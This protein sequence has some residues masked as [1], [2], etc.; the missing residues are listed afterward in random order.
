MT[1]EGKTQVQLAAP[2]LTMDART[3]SSIT[4]KWNKVENASGYA[5]YLDGDAVNAAIDANTTS[6]KFE[7]LEGEA[8]TSYAFQIV[9]LGV[10][11]RDY[12]DS[13]LSEKFNF[14]TQAILATPELIATANSDTEIALSWK[15]VA[16]ATGYTLTYGENTQ[17]LEASDTSFVAK[18]LRAGTEYAFAITATSE[19]DDYVNSTTANASATTL[20]KLATPE[21]TVTEQTENSIKLNWTGIEGANGYTLVYSKSEDVAATSVPLVKGS[22]SYVATGLESGAKYVFQLVAN[23]EAGKSVD[24]EPGATNEVATLVKINPPVNVTVVEQTQHSIKITWEGDP[25]ATSYTVTYGLTGQTKTQTENVNAAEFELK[26]LGEVES[27]TFQIVANPSGEEFVSSDPATIKVSTLGQLA[28]PEVYNIQRSETTISFEWSAVGQATGYTLTYGEQ[29]GAEKTFTL[30]ATTKKYSFSKL[31]EG[32]TYTFKLSAESDGFVGSEQNVFDV[33]THEQLAAPTITSTRTTTSIRLSWEPITNA[34]S[35]E[36]YRNG[37]LMNTY[38]G[39]DLTFDSTGLEQGTEYTFKL[40]AI[41]DKPEDVAQS[42]YLDSSS[43]IKVTTQKQLNAPTLEYVT[44]SLDNKGTLDD[45]SDDKASIT[46]RWNAVDDATSYTLR[47]R[48]DEGTW[49]SVDASQYVLQ[50]NAYTCEVKNLAT[51]TTYEFEVIARGD[52]PN[53][54]NSEAAT[55]TQVTQKQLDAPKLEFDARDLNSITVKWNAVDDETENGYTLGYRAGTTGEFTQVD[56]ANFTK[57]GDAYTCVVSGL[58]EATNYQFQLVAKGTEN[59]DY[60]DSE[61]ATLKDVTKGTLA[62]PRNLAATHDMSSIALT[63]DAVEHATKYQVVF[64]V[65]DSVTPNSIEVTEPRFSMESLGPGVAYT[66]T[67]TA[68]G[69]ENY[70]LASEAAETTAQTQ[71]KLVASAPELQARATDSLTVTWEAVEN[72]TRY[73]LYRDGVKVYEGSNTSYTDRG[74][75]NTVLTPGASYVY[76]VVALGDAAAVGDAGNYLASEKSTQATFVT[77][78]RLD[79]PTLE[80]GSRTE[81]SI[82][83][84]WS[85]V[86]N[87]SGYKLEYRV[88]GATE[89]TTENVDGTSY[90]A[91]GLTPAAT[92]EFKLTAIGDGDPTA[93]AT[94]YLDSETS[95]ILEKNTQATLDAPTLTLKEQSIDSIT[96]SW[97]LIENATGYDLYKN[98]AKITTINSGET[99]SYVVTDLEAGGSY[100]Y[101]IKAKG[102]S[103][104][105]PSDP[106]FMDSGKSVALTIN[107]L[108]EPTITVGET[109]NESIPLSWNTPTDATGTTLE[110]R[111]KGA[112]EWTAVELAEGA[113][114]YTLTGQLGD[115][116]TYEFRVVALGDLEQKF[117]STA[118]IEEATT[119][120]KLA[121]PTLTYVTREFDDNETAGNTSDDTA[122]ISFTWTT[123]EGADNYTLYYKANV[124]GATE[125]VV[126]GLTATDATG[127]T[128]SNLATGT[129]YSIQ[130][131]ANGSG[132]YVSSDRSA[133]ITATTQ[134][135]LAQPTLKLKERTTG[136]ITV[137]W[138]GNDNATGYALKIRQGD[139]QVFSMTLGAGQTEF[140]Y[141]LSSGVAYTYELVA[142]GT[143]NGDYIDSEKATLTVATKSQLAA[144]TLTSA[145]VEGDLTKVTISWDAIDNATGY[146]LYLGGEKVYDGENTSYI[147]S[148]LEAGA[149]Y[150]FTIKAKGNDNENVAVTEVPYVDSNVSSALVVTK[151]AKPTIAVGERTANSIAITWDEVANAT[152][153]EIYLGDTM[154]DSKGANATRSYTFTGLEGAT[155]YN[156]LKVVAVG[157]GTT[158]VSTAA[159]ETATTK[160]QLTASK[161]SLTSRTLNSAGTV[162]TMT[163]SWVTSANATGYELYLDGVAVNAALDEDAT[164][165]TFENLA[166]GK[167]YSIQLVAKGSGEYVDSAKS[168]ALTQK[169]QAKLA[170][171][172]INVGGRTHDSIAL[173]WDS[174]ANATSYKL[175]G[176]NNSNGS[177]VVDETLTALEYTISGLAPGT[178]Y[179]FTIEAVASSD[180]YVSNSREVEATTKTQL[181][182][183][184]V[185][186]S[187]SVDDNNAIL[188]GK[189]TATWESVANATGYK[190]VCTDIKTQEKKEQDVDGTTASFEELENGREYKIEV[191]AKGAGEFV[192]SEAGVGSCTTAVQLDSPTIASVTRT[193]ASITVNWTLPLPDGATA[194]QLYLYDEDGVEVGNGLANEEENSHSFGNLIPGKKY[195]IKLYAVADGFVTSEAATQE[196]KTQKQLDQVTNPDI[197]FEEGNAILTWSP[198]ANAEGY[199]LKY[200][201]KGTVDD[202]TSADS[203]E[204]VGEVVHATIYGVDDDTPYGYTLITKAASGDDPDYIDSE[205][206]EGGFEHGLGEE[207]Y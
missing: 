50:N 12:A 65:K 70:Y 171:P 92:Y 39:T 187:Q 20:A 190:V 178:G 118:K 36:L 76:E 60:L 89:W 164:S 74:F 166:A 120:T 196:V 188:L 27:Y 185:T 146:E 123:S 177:K 35:Y 168:E 116:T 110:Y 88:K 97:N 131:V 193:T 95:A 103:A 180:D 57:D 43:E 53:Y 29:G 51:E 81:T 9:A 201:I 127:Y 104:L 75:V 130:L 162:A 195:T 63:W 206:F 108:A 141:N 78:K 203:I 18:G 59:K 192:N 13:E 41:G 4:V 181:S 169:T 1:T 175:T 17:Y 94:L 134:A 73:E 16:N 30:P 167:E 147:Q 33:T 133:S 186:V 49:S 66:F 182:Q 152:G 150:S 37:E 8:G 24:S 122:S 119:K 54:V 47:Y 11:N 45:T 90:D 21:L 154:V 200:G 174:V 28:T 197:R 158:F 170:K 40:K 161:P 15:P 136:R 202:W 109:T 138:N 144:P 115:A 145:P 155:E 151:L 5:L 159:T 165:Y 124:E 107:K 7:D 183:P 69:D 198:V 83:V 173:S 86:A 117:V 184:V 38:N 34:S 98:N 153:Y 82:T 207:D 100:S 52:D 25:R 61:A 48:E 84:N 72:A 79:Q 121:T 87:A 19:V 42:Y 157:N 191:V 85:A 205:A 139:S 111:V 58:T 68:L 46:V 6:Y 148:E 77:Q 80:Y 2:E 23:G 137:Q 179:S 172:S 56:S 149:S 126:T 156:N 31:D 101:Q 140:G 112:T 142:K 194:C 26:D 128:L 32:T 125:Q 44:R 91:N 135:K 176:Y 113:T 64:G 55:I 93:L 143:T 96:L 99:T 10:E 204:V 189:L 14:A 160:T 163:V 22:T 105:N 199:E 3:T 132:D 106:N 62:T 129:E 67:I 114:S 71:A 102:D